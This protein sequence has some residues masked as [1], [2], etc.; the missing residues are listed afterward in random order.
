MLLGASNR[1]RVSGLKKIHPAI[2]AEAGYSEM[3][4]IGP[5]EKRPVPSISAYQRIDVVWF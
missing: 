3:F 4:A 1:R 5:I 2:P